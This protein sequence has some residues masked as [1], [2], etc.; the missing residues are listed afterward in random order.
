[1]AHTP[2]SDELA[3]RLGSALRRI[4]RARH[5]LRIATNE[6]AGEL[7][8]LKIEIEILRFRDLG[9]GE[10]EIVRYGAH[11]RVL[12]PGDVTAFR[13][14]NLSSTTVDVTLLFIDSGYGIAPI[15]PEPGGFDDNR[16]GPGKTLVTPRMRVTDET[17]GVE[18]LVAIAVRAT[19]QRVDF[20]CLAQPTLPTTR[21]GPDAAMESPLGRLLE[22]AMYGRGKT[23]GL[24]KT[25]LRTHSV[26]LL[27]W[28]NVPKAESKNDTSKSGS[29]KK[30]ANGGRAQGSE[31]FPALNPETFVHTGHSD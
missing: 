30:E 17:V 10:G 14:Q 2:D 7:S 1:L 25:E 4:A 13:L 3:E 22:R 6:T 26:R 15:F 19:R 18:H 12:N 5:L 8:P 16:L 11:G 23:R 20:S 24:K 28:L 31:F 27:S 9:E 29:A 21:A